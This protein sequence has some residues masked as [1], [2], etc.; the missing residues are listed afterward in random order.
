MEEALA[1]P[2][3]VKWKQAIDSELQS[4]D[5][6]DTYTW[7]PLPPGVKA[8]KS[9]IILKIKPPADGNPERFKA[10]LVAKG[11][12]QIEGIDF[13]ANKIYAPVIGKKTLRFTC[14]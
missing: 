4:I 5:H 1:G 14:A 7:E 11:Y 12:S 13:Q 8:V 3:R 2:D 6:H 10:R 9:G